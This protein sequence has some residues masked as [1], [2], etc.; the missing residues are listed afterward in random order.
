MYISSNIMAINLE[1]EVG[2]AM[3]AQAN[4]LP[5]NILKLLG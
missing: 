3:L 4:T 5:Q 1:T 2:Q